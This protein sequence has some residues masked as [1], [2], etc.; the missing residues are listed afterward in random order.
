[1]YKFYSILG[2]LGSIFPVLALKL[3]DVLTL[4]VDSSE[5]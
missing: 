3:S 1:M 2:I 4:I 5:D